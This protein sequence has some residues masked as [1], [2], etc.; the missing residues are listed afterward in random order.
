MSVQDD[1]EADIPWV[2]WL[3]HQAQASGVTSMTQLLSQPDADACVA[4]FVVM[5]PAKIYQPESAQF[6][7]FG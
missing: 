2:S 6:C 1:V 7:N 5:T 3:R 4:F